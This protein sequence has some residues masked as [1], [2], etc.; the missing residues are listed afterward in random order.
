MSSQEAE[1]VSPM[2][3]TPA[4]GE[5][6]LDTWRFHW[7]RGARHRADDHRRMWWNEGCGQTTKDG[8]YANQRLNLAA[9][10][11]AHRRQ[12]KVSNRTREIRPSGIIGGP[13]ETWPWWK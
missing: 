3:V 7:Q 8:A 1:D 5:G 10:G 2:A 13:P 4:G 11:K 6:T 9:D 12:A